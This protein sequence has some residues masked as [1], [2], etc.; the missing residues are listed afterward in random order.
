LFQRFPERPLRH[1]VSQVI[2]NQHL[3]K[4]QQQTP[5]TLFRINSYA[6]VPKRSVD[7]KAL[8]ET[9]SPLDATLT[10]NQGRGPQLS[11]TRPLPALSE[12][13]MDFSLLVRIQ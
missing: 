12:V 7:S 10:K 2:Q 1:P 6:S 4:V 13:S 5:L 11:L 3:Q 8:T 9:L